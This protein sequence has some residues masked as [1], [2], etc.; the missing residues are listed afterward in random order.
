MPAE[1]VTLHVSINCH[2]IGHSH[3]KYTDVTTSM[4]T[5][6]DFPF[7]VLAKPF[8]KSCFTKKVNRVSNDL[9]IL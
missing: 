4:L 6:P 7:G 3:F 9:L 2:V 5:D 8:L 1:N